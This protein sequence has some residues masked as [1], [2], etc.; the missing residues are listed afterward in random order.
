MNEGPTGFL[1]ATSGVR[2]ANCAVRGASAI[3]A[4][5]FIRSVREQPTNLDV[6]PPAV[7]VAPITEAYV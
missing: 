4:R 7:R 1:A 5:A 3:N 2:D 6:H